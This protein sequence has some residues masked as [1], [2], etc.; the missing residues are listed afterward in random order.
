MGIANNSLMSAD[1]LKYFNSNLK[2]LPE[3]LT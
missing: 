3:D 1:L 2:L